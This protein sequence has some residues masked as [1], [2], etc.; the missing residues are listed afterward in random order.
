MERDTNGAAKKTAG[1]SGINRCYIGCWLI[2]GIPTER[3]RFPENDCY[4]R[5]RSI[6]LLAAASEDS[7]FGAVSGC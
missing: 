4:L 7:G 5:G 3:G 1:K 6:G 2:H